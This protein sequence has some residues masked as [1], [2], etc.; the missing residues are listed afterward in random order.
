[1]L[2]AKL[3]RSKSFGGIYYF[4]TRKYIQSILCLQFMQAQ[5]SWYVN[6]SFK[7][8]CLTNSI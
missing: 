8:Y 1:M 2:L 7:L 3:L 4:D 5:F 6:N